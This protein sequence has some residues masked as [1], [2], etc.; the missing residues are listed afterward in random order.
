MLNEPKLYRCNCN[1]LM[2]VIILRHYLSFATIDKFLGAR[3]DSCT[4]QEL[5]RVGFT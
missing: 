5:G 4:M 3:T 1:Y 2:K